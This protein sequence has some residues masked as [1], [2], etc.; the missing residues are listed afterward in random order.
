MKKK[1]ANTVPSYL[2]VT[3]E[4]RRK[5]NSPYVEYPLSKIGVVIKAL[6]DLRSNAIAEGYYTE[7]KS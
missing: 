1:N 7:E 2:V 3:F 5:S 6:E 4:N